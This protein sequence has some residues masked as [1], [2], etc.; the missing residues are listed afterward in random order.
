MPWVRWGRARSE[1]FPIV[2][3]TRQGSVLSPT[4]FAIYMDEI[5]VKLRGRL[6]RGGCVHECLGLCR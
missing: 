3:G 4:L 6:L 2:N 1:L 5:L